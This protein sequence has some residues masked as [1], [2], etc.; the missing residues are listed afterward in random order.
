MPCC[1][2]KPPQCNMQG[3]S[4]SWKMPTRLTLIRM[5]MTTYRDNVT[6]SVCVHFYFNLFCHLSEDPST[7]T[8]TFLK[9]QTA[10]THI[11]N[12]QVSRWLVRKQDLRPSQNLCST[13]ICIYRSTMP[14]NENNCPVTGPHTFHQIV[15]LKLNCL[16][17]EGPPPPP[18]NPRQWVQQ[19]PSLKANLKIKQKWSWGTDI[20]W[21]AVCWQNM[22]G[23]VSANGG[24]W[25]QQCFIT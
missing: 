16:Q 8:N 21:S 7:P 25:Y 23:K 1:W 5:Q 15:V 12:V 17:A 9:L 14:T 2:A 6:I 20:P 19:Y 10:I 24:P 4:Q 11:E 13:A 22:K 18:F 3:W